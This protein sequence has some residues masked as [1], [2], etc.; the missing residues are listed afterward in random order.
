LT[1]CSG[2]AAGLAGFA[3][4]ETAEEGA[5]ADT[6]AGCGRLAAVRKSS[7]PGATCSRSPRG[8]GSPSKRRTNSRR[9]H[10]RGSSTLR[11]LRFSELRFGEPALHS[12]DAGPGPLIRRV[13]DDDALQEIKRFFGRGRYGRQPKPGLFAQRVKARGLQKV[14]P[15]GSTP[16]FARGRFSLLNEALCLVVD[17]KPTGHH[18]ICFP[19]RHA[20]A[21]EYDCNTTW[22]RGQAGSPTF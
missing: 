8:G 12:G 10:G 7:Q 5:A 22:P 11:G 19:L 13:Q 3:G 16:S 6:L 17:C 14:S 21:F 2:F 20:I 18:S 15:R 4:V 1:L 9:R